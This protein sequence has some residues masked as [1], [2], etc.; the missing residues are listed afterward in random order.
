M[1]QTFTVT[2]SGTA[3]SGA[4]SVTVTGNDSA[5][6]VPSANTCTG[7]LA[8]A[9]KCTV[10]IT[11]SPSNI[12]NEAATLTASGTPG[13][14]VSA[15][16]TGTGITPGGISVS[17]STF[18][19]PTTTAGATSAAQV[20]TFT[21]GGSA[22]TAAPA[23]QMFGGDATQFTIGTGAGNTCT[24]AI[25]PAGT[26][27]V[28]VT[29]TPGAAGSFSSS[30]Q[31]T[32]GS[33]TVAASVSGTGV[34]GAHLSIAPIAGAFG[35]QIEGVT[36]SPVTFTVTNQGGVATAALVDAV[37]GANAAD[38]VI[39]T[40][41]CS[42]QALAAA[43]TCQLLV[44]FKAST[45]GA[46]TA[47]LTV[48]D[49]ATDVATA[50][51]TGSGAT[52]SGLAFNPAGPFAFSSTIGT[53]ATAQTLTLTNSATGATTG[54]LHAAFG[55]ANAGDFSIVTGSD[56][57]SG[58]TLAA[59]QSC[60]VNVTFDPSA[61]SELATLTIQGT[62]GGSA[63][64]TLNGTGIS[65]A[66]LSAAPP[67]L[68]FGTIPTGTTSAPQTTTI[69]NL[70]GVATGAV[71]VVLGG[72]NAGDFNETTTC[73]ASLAAGTG[74]CTVS[75]TYTPGLV[76]NETASIAVSAAPGG[77]VNIPLTGSGIGPA[78]LAFAASS[79]TSFNFYGEP[80]SNPWPITSD[81]T[82]AGP[83]TFTVT[84]NGTSSTGK[85]AV[86][87]GAGNFANDFVIAAATGN[88]C[89]SGTTALAGGQS[90]TIRVS[91]VPLDADITS[92]AAAAG[93]AVFMQQVLTITPTSGT[94]LSAA[95]AGYGEHLMS[96]D[97]NAA[98]F[99]DGAALTTTFLTPV[100]TATVS[101]AP[102]FRFCNNAE[103]QRDTTADYAGDTLASVGGSPFGATSFLT[104]T[105]LYG[106]GSLDPKGVSSRVIVPANSPKIT[107]NTAGYFTIAGDTCSNGQI[108]PGACCLV[109]V[110]FLPTA[111]V[112]GATASLTLT[113]LTDTLDGT[114]TAVAVVADTYQLTGS[115]TSGLTVNDSAQAGNP[116]VA[117]YNF[118]TEGTQQP[119]TTFGSS[120]HSTTLTL[121]CATA[122]CGEVTTDLSDQANFSVST[123][124]AITVN[125]YTG[126]NNL[127]VTFQPTAAGQNFSATLTFTGAGGDKTTLALSGTS[128]TASSLGLTGTA[129]FGSVFAG[130][131]QPEN[132]TITNN[133]GQNSPALGLPGLSGANPGYWA[134]TDPNSCA[135]KVLAAGGTCVVVV[136]FQP[137][138]NF[139]LGA[140]TATLGAGFANT[141]SLTGT[142]VSPLSIVGPANTLLQGVTGGVA[143]NPLVFTVKNSGQ[144]AIAAGALAYTFP[145]DFGTSGLLSSSGAGAGGCNAALPSGGT[146][147]VSVSLVTPTA[148]TE[149]VEL[150]V[151]E[152][153]AAVPQAG[154]VT[155]T[156]CVPAADGSALTPAQCAT[157]TVP[158]EGLVAAPPHLVI[159]SPTSGA[160]GVPPYDFGSTTI[161]AA[162]T[163]ALFTVTNT[164]GIATGDLSVT[165]TSVLPGTNYTIVSGAENTCAGLALAGGGATCTFAAEFTPGNGAGVA[166]ANVVGTVGVTDGTGPG[167]DTYA[168][169][170][171]TD[172]A[173]DVTVSPGSYF[174]GNVNPGATAPTQVFTVSNTT[175]GPVV[176]TATANF[177]VGAAGNNNVIFSL[178]AAG[179]TC[180]VGGTVNAGGTCNIEVQMNT[181]AALAGLS[182]EQLIIANDGG[183][184]N[185]YSALSGFVLTPV[186]SDADQPWTR[187]LRRCGHHPGLGGQDADRQERRCRRSHSRCRGLQ[188]RGSGRLQARRRHL[189][190]HYGCWQRR[191]LHL[192]RG[193][194][195]DP[196][197]GQHCHRERHG[198]QRQLGRC[199]HG[200]PVCDGVLDRSHRQ[201]RAGCG[202]GRQ[203]AH[204]TVLRERGVPER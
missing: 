61:A 126:Q 175:A 86:A 122:N 105:P 183:A 139:A 57:C 182:T 131:T 192:R 32:A 6:F 115:T 198:D 197:S 103:P 168:V 10:A 116:P 199:L 64:A 164:G 150:Q 112:T 7:T 130:S 12:G 185:V 191:N 59:G 108:N 25:A 132:I 187:W 204:G 80:N 170:G 99:N 171:Y 135:G 129:A 56:S 79:P 157:G 75:V 53:P 65:A 107:G 176:L 67:A 133:G 23:V 138:T 162:S 28:S 26:C 55:G 101:A 38:F 174:F 127:V 71:S 81:D 151:Q 142:D 82:T 87:I 69:S 22:A 19:F 77:T 36:S 50:D 16:L 78:A 147:T 91:F 149:Y 84:N 17:P 58:S 155:D 166:G 137:P 29:F 167:T 42:G 102:S 153:I 60:T 110:Q 136:T 184:K 35:Q 33:S 20:F 30:V 143:P 13:G 93:G 172:F 95:L 92:G 144:V 21:N 15:S 89:V 90:C 189:Q 73:N 118:N 181:G 123:N 188:R 114:A 161:G 104:N 165:E 177:G 106:F 63:V 195:A 100:N 193:V 109:T 14:S 113:G 140:V 18:Q 43:A 54:T 3:A 72:A 202:A 62:P 11:F 52:A 194:R 186:D 125:P 146:C 1:A 5:D 48:T 47:S 154:V 196:G 117:A 145:Q 190:R 121:K 45:T 152:I 46:E 44:T 179:T 141:L 128:A 96:Y 134:V 163:Q 68:S 120:S 94:A 49:S 31:L 27:T 76:G 201:W 156:N 51:L 178:V 4:V 9:A 66:A 200:A 70:G 98:F 2:N 85:L 41:T 158:I 203:P 37:G 148:G 97:S 8:P 74:T 159:T 173:T 88:D 24:A 83:V 169:T 39:G 160:A 111:L 34:A 124:P 119:T 180:T 40:D